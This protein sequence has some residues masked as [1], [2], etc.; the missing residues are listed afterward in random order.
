MLP[1][2]PRR[3]MA[4]L[5]LSARVGRLASVATFPRLRNL[6]WLRSI[7]TFKVPKTCSTVL[8]RTRIASGQRS[9]RACIASITSSCSPPFDAALEAGRTVYLHG[10][11]GAAGWR[12]VTVQRQPMF[13]A[14]DAPGHRLASRAAIVVGI[15]LVH[16]VLL[17]PAPIGLGAGGERFGADRYDAGLLAGQR[18]RA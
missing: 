11:A 18:L 17:A 14:G 13:K 10:E 2:T 7:Q 4:R 12:G 3:A 8:R 15:G 16:E 5:I 1:G 9:S 6:K